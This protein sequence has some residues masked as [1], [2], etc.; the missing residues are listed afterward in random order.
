MQRQRTMISV[1][2]LL[3]ILLT[4]CGSAG[5]SDNP[6][7][8]TEN[9]DT[10]T[11]AEETTTADTSP[12]PKLEPVDCG[13]KEYNILSREID[14]YTFPYSELYSEEQN[15]D[16][17]NDAVYER[18]RYIEDKYNLRLN[19]T[20][21][22]R[23]E[24]ASGAKRSISAGDSDYDLVFPMVADA[25]SMSLDGLFLN[26]NDIPHIDA[27][28][29]WWR[30]SILEDVS[31][32]GRNYFI[33]GDLNL[34]SLNDVGV[35]YFNKDLAAQRNITDI[36]DTVRAG[37][38]TIDRFSEYCK[39]V[40]SD[41]NG[42]TVLNGDDMFGL[43]CNAFCWQPLFAGTDSLI[44]EKDKDDKPYLAWGSERNMAVMG[45]I[46]GLLNDRSSTILVNQFPELEDAGGWGNASIK[47][48]TEDRALFWIE[49]I[50]G[51]LQ[52][53]DMNTDFGL[54]PMPKYDDNQANYTSYMHTSNASTCC[55]PVTSGDTDLAGRILTDMAYMS[56][57]TIR[58]AY[59]EKT[60]KGK[61]SR[62]EE[63]GGM[64][65]IIYSDIRLDLT[66]AMV[67]SGL[68]IDDTMRSAAIKN[69]TDLASMIEKKKSEKIIDKNA[70]KILSLDH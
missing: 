53:R 44:I 45:K 15:G 12:D 33:I 14:G 8:T 36:Y 52:L 27:E 70:D 56:Y 4:S 35:V 11:I 55:V 46:I 31:I 1:I 64:L 25:F 3:S 6:D 37:K 41:V 68:P 66:F 19:V 23:T 50:Y 61:A 49:I 17:I 62:D 63:S 57:K 7:A 30:K 42:D 28:M 54:L 20:E 22:K 59:Y 58:P 29:P 18:N 26:V 10:E 65:D 32:G 38:W 21:L 51:V 60:L 16:I 24:F 48:F 67:F 34:S 2:L 13:G 40:T 39:G 69:V 5:S 47:M 9:T 43:T